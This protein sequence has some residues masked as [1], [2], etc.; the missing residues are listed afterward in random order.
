MGFSKWKSENY[1]VWKDFEMLHLDFQGF[2]DPEQADKGQGIDGLQGLTG[3]WPSPVVHV[4]LCVTGP[5]FIWLQRPVVRKVIEII[6]RLQ[7]FLKSKCISS[8]NHNQSG[9][10]YR[11]D[12]PS[13]GRSLSKLS[14]YKLI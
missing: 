4:I 14:L 5:R 3:H 6:Q 13:T 9:E 1:L 7:D 12:G 10:S 11:G 8:V 2:V